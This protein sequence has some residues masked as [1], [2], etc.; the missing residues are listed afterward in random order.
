M[1]LLRTVSKILEGLNVSNG[2]KLTLSSDM[3]QATYGMG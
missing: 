2:T 1:H 3:D